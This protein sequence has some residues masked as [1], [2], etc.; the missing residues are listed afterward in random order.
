M[1]TRPIRRPR[2]FCPWCVFILSE[3]SY[4][5]EADFCE[6][7]TVDNVIY[8][9]QLHPL[10]ALFELDKR[11]DA[12]GT[13]RMRQTP[14]YLAS[15]WVEAFITALIVCLAIGV[16]DVIRVQMDIFDVDPDFEEQETPSA[17]EPGASEKRAATRRKA[18]NESNTSTLAS[19]LARNIWRV[20]VVGLIAFCV[21]FVV[22]KLLDGKRVFGQLFV[23]PL[24]PA[25]DATVAQTDAPEHSKP[26]PL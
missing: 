10:M 12:V 1:R 4:R 3:V 9:Q 26:T 22:Y 23:S 20:L 15:L 2:F 6:P 7:E 21:P 14:P 17:P 18:R 8:R 5:G 13:R 25:E 19:V 24:R 16:E 11:K